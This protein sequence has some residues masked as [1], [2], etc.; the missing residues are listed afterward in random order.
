MLSLLR[1]TVPDGH[2]MVVSGDPEDTRERHGV[3]AV[4]RADV[5]AVLSEAYRSRVVIVGGGGLL[6]DQWGFRPEYALSRDAGDIPGYLGPALAAAAVGRPVLVWGVGVGPFRGRRSRRWVKAL[7]EIASDFTVR[8]EEDRAELESIGIRDSLV[9]GDPAWLIQPLDLPP[10]L[11][12]VLSHLPRPLVGVAPRSWG[13][14]RVQTRREQVLAEALDAFCEKSGGSVVFVPMQELEGDDFD[15]R[16]C[17]QRIADLMSAPDVHMVPPGLDPAQLLTVLGR[18]ELALNMRLHGTIL[19]ALGG[20]PS[21]SIS[22]D[23]KVTRLAGE[24]GLSRF[25]LS[26]EEVSWSRLTE[27]LDS[28]WEDYPDL[29]FAMHMGSEAMRASARS[30]RPV[31]KRALSGVSEADPFTDQQAIQMEL[32][33][34]LTRNLSGTQTRL[35]ESKAENLELRNRIIRGEDKLQLARDELRLARDEL[36]LAGGVAVGQTSCGWPETS[37]SW[38]RKRPGSS[39]RR[40]TISMGMR[41]EEAICSNWNSTTSVKPAPSSW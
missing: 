9:V 32:M 33:F 3:M 30:G 1:E 25:C 35:D 13:S 18:C 15:D 2:W 11:S 28:V 21:V 27:S 31:V 17:C 22:Y 36:R 7:A 6:S 37:C 23:P 14:A 26:D 8:T 24:L 29:S 12:G 5:P 39:C 40:R 19:A 38:P 10:D 34:A 4:D 16:G 20:T 41:S